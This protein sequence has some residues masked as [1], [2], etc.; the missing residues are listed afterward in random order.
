G[1]AA[2]KFRCAE[3]LAA[4]ELKIPRENE[5]SATAVDDEAGAALE[6]RPGR[7]GV[8]FGDCGGGV[9]FE[10]SAFPSESHGGGG[11][12]PRMVGS[13]QSLE[14]GRIEGPVDLPVVAEK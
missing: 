13:D 14:I 4:L 12:G 8:P 5:C 7:A 10:F 9:D 2:Q 11:T 1:R 6:D 3:S